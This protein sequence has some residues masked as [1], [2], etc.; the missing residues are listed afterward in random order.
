[1]RE[2]QESK[3]RGGAT[4]P[5][6]PPPRA[7]PVGVGVPSLVGLDRSAAVKALRRAGLSAG[8]FNEVD[9]KQRIGRV[10]ASR[11]AAGALLA[12]GAEVDLD[13]SAGLAVP[14]LKGLGRK[15]AELALGRA[16]LETGVV[17]RA[18]S[19]Q[20]GGR[21]LSSEPAAGS[22]VA[23]GSA[24][25]LVVTQHGAEVPAVAGKGRESAV[26]A[27]KAAG[28]AVEQRV[29]IVT[30]PGEVDTV[31]AQSVPAGR[32]AQPGRTIVITVGVEGQ[33][34]PDP[35]EPEPDPTPTPS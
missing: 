15:A 9:S 11:P 16:G 33:T 21:V 1:D 2:R 25:A 6:P 28:F 19:A 14:E 10:L 24:V 12:K 5:A 18:C 23:G 26:T 31:L 22:R 34:G 35:G 13:V 4:E 17:S 32:C 8:T 7:E 3:V 29:Q 30:E 27:L 20:P